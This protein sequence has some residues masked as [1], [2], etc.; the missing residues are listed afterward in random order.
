MRHFTFIL[1]IRIFHSYFKMCLSALL[2]K[3]TN[4]NLAGYRI[5]GHCEPVTDVTGVAIP[6]L[7]VPLF[8]NEFRK[9]AGKNG[10][11]NDK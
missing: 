2:S 6:R 11:Y 10:L 7:D 8:V 3:Y 1:G 9:T 4:W 5:P